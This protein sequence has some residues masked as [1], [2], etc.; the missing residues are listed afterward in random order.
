GYPPPVPTLPL[1]LL[2]NT[3]WPTP[4]AMGTLLA[5][6]WLLQSL[7]FLDFIINKGLGLATFL[8]LTALLVP[9]LLTIILPLAVF[10]GAAYAFKNMG[11]ESELTTLYATGWSRLWVLTP[12]LM[13][14]I[15]ATALGFL[16]HL[17]VLPA[18]T[19]AFKNMQTQLRN[20]QSDLLL[21]EATFN[22]LGNGLMVYVGQ[23]TGPTSF[24]QL[25]V[26]DTR[27]PAK[28]TTWMAE[29]GELTV[30][31]GHPRLLLT[32]GLQQTLRTSNGVTRPETLSFSEHNL[33]LT[34]QFSP[35]TLEART[36]ELEEYSLTTLWHGTQA[37]K[38]EATRRLL[39]PLAPIP[40][41]LWAAAWLLKVPGRSSNFGKLAIA[42]T[43]AIAYVA[44]LLALRGAAEDSALVMALQP[45]LPLALTAFSLY[46]IK[47]V[48]YG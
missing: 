23:R 10:A 16:L 45:L 13:L 48:S 8:H 41:V 33:D 47:V 14:A 44:A 29:R 21:D 26:H 25:L 35:V 17:V 32:H 28:P 15:V 20:G 12:A 40:L 3:H 39:W 11:D 6:I 24:M 5:I 46:K 22:Q 7:K 18:S 42:T 1:Y 2:R 27:K 36:P 9:S 34:S 4:M 19:T 30:Q 38:A 43:G 37:M 31:N